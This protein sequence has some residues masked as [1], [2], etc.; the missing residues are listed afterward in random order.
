MT[1]QIVES[2]GSEI[3]GKR[4]AARFARV[5]ERT[6]DRAIKAGALKVGRVGGRVL[7]RRDDLMRA[8]F[9]GD[10]AATVA[11]K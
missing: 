4:E 7:I 6:L 5:S 10:G 2:V 1:T 11:S 8:I 3:M 9:D